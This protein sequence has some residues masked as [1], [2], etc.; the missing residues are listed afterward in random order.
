MFSCLRPEPKGQI[1]G[2]VLRFIMGD[3]KERLMR[4]W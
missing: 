3:R 1:G 4:Q 2:R